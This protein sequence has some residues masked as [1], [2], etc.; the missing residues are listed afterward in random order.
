MRRRQRRKYRVGVR[1]VNFT[2]IGLVASTI[3]V[4]L[5]VTAP[6]SAPPAL[7]ASPAHAVRPGLP[8]LPLQFAA[9]AVAQ[10]PVSQLVI[11]TPESASFATGGAPAATTEVVSQTASS[12]ATEVPTTAVLPLA[13]PSS[14]ITAAFGRL[15]HG[16]GHGSANGSGNALGIEKSGLAAAGASPHASLNA[17]RSDGNG[18]DGNGASANGHGNGG[19][20]KSEPIGPAAPDTLVSP[21]R[22]NATAPSERDPGPGPQA[23]YPVNQGFGDR[24]PATGEFSGG[25]GQDESPAA[26]PGRASP[27]QKR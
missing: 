25:Q 1:T 12:A 16:A 18:N 26:T 22:A 15:D 9:P 2:S 13:Q 24:R 17:N 21:V 10:E 8:T 4:V 7:F 3:I 6:S 23:P 14:A 5:E 11:G 20:L 19:S 27:H